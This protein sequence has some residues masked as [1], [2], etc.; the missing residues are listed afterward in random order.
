[1]KIKHDKKVDAKYISLFPK[2]KVVSTQK[3]E[4]W[5]LIDSDK[6]GR[7]IGIEILDASKH[8]VSFYITET[9]VECFP[10]PAVSYRK[11]L[12]TKMSKNFIAGEQINVLSL[13]VDNTA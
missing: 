11:P 3:Q 9:K 6:K 12:L 1:M 5:L 2:E 4:D 10:A 8:T 7:V 13:S